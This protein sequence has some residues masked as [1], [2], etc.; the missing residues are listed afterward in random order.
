MLWDKDICLGVCWDTRKLIMKN[1]SRF[2][3]TLFPV[4]IYF[5][6]PL[7]GILQISSLLY[8]RKVFI[9]WLKHPSEFTISCCILYLLPL[10]LFLIYRLMNQLTISHNCVLLMQV[11]PKKFALLANWQREYTMEDILVQLKKEMASPHNRKL[12][13]PPE[14]TYF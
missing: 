14:G 8:F 3:V 11:E 9:A 6:C 10:V 13:Q 12:V 2:V 1:I 7:V 4:L 5:W